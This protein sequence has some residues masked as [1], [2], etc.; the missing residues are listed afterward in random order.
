M[1]SQK[2]TI[3]N[4]LLLTD[5]VCTSR[6]YGAYIA[7]PRRRICDLRKAGYILEGRKCQK[8]DFHK[9]Y[10]KEW[11]LIG[12]K[13]MTNAYVEELRKIPVIDGQ[14]LPSGIPFRIKE[15]LQTSLF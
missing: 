6:M 4:M 8:H 2:Q 12:T 15:V 3:L 10:S 11:H 14:N 1:E 7:D 5:W 9:G 13:P